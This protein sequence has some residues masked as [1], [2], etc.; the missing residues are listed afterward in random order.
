M[1]LGVQP[2][3]LYW[4]TNPGHDVKFFLGLSWRQP[5]V[6]L[7]WPNPVVATHQIMAD[8]R[9]QPVVATLLWDGLQAGCKS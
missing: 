8:G 2:D 1:L 7:M 6:E 3:E 9:I 5:S 4:S